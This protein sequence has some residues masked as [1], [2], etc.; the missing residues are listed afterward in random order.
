MRRNVGP[1]GD[2]YLGQDHLLLVNLTETPLSNPVL[3]LNSSGNAFSIP[4][5]KRGVANNPAFGG[6]GAVTLGELP[7]EKVYATLIGE[8]EE[9]EV[10]VGVGGLI[11][12]AIPYDTLDV[13]Y[14]VP[15]TMFLDGDFNLDGD[16]DAA[17]YVVWRKTDGSA[18][19]Y[20]LWRANF[21]QSI[22][23]GS[24]RSVMVPEPT[25]ALLLALS[26][27][28]GCLV[29]RSRTKGRRCLQ[30]G[31]QAVGHWAREHQSAG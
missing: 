16:V 14:L 26:T 20:N 17:D 2:D 15:F 8:D 5:L 10:T 25:A 21:G 18:S 6:A 11:A 28:L 29:R 22:G 1:T 19:G 23:N 27:A 7:A 31:R 30:R 3:G 24:E 12:T 9:L 4:L 13:F